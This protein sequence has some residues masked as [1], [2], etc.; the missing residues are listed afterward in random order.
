MTANDL[1]ATS[2][3]AALQAHQLTAVDLLQSC[4][5]RITER[6]MIVGAWTTLNL[7]R[8]YQQAEACDQAH[9]A[10]QSLGALHGIPIGIKDTFATKDLPTEWGTPIHA[11][12]YFKYDAAVVERLRSAGAMILGKTVTTEYAASHANQTTNPHDSDHTPGGSS[13]GS[14]AAVADHMVPIAIGTQMMGSVLR[15]AAYCGVLGFK[16]SFGVISRYGV[17][18][19]S[20]ELD[21]VGIFARDMRDIA[22]VLS[23]LAGADDRDADCYGSIPGLNTTIPHLLKPDPLRFAVVLGPYEHQMDSDAATALD[24]GITS[25]ASAG[26]MMINVNLPQIFDHYFDLVQVL[27]AAGMATNHGQDY[28]RYGDLMSAELRQT[29]ERGRELSAMAYAQARH[30]VVHY[31]LTLSQLF[32]DVDAIITPVTTGAAPQGLESTGSPIFC[33]LWTLC[34]LPAITIPVGKTADGLPLGIQL[35]GQRL[36]DMKLLAIADWVMQRIGVTC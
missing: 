33:A 15:P 28:D 21:H 9:A 17:M 22:L 10:G 11:E 29:I 14:A 13:S 30:I 8:A 1:S 20:R 7:D 19:S 26:A 35:V 12:Q 3:L 5:Q 32:A 31:G 36:A 34:G 6:E 18:P 2:A 25:L 4:Q 23:I 16:P 24:N 27:V